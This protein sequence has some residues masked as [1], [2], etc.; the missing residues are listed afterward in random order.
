MNKKLI[1]FDCDGVLADSEFVACE[2]FAEVL[3][4][5]GYIITTQE[6]VKKFTGVNEHDAREMIFEESSIK[7]PKNYWELEQPRLHDA[8]EKDL[9][10]L[11]QPVL[12]FLK[13]SNIERCVA[14]NSSKKH[15]NN[16]LK[17]T[18][19]SH[20]FLN[21]NIFSSDQVAKPKPA[22]DLFLFAAKQMG[23]EPKDC[24]VIEDSKAGTQA[25]INAGMEVFIFLAGSHTKNDAYRTQ[26]EAYNKPIVNSCEE[27]IEAL[28]LALNVTDAAVDLS[29]AELT[30]TTK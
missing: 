23:Y 13:T 25:A 21:E 7:I 12:E 16:C 18:E 29:P 14:S 26:M 19:Q 20:Y 17:I 1:I 5:Y 28:Y 10:A 6:C 15:I 9:K 27:L 24:I 11:M 4:S 2:I 8:Y 3:S 30:E 22:P